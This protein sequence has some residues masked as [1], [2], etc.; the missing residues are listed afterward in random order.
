[1]MDNMYALKDDPIH[2]PRCILIAR[3]APVWSFPK[4]RPG[5]KANDRKPR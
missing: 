3:L 5:Y 4:T 1:M 2:C